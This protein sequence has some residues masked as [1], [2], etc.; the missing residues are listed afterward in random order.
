M[1]AA[2]IMLGSC[3]S[4]VQG[5]DQSII[6][7]TNPP[8]ATCTLEREGEEIGAVLSTPASVTVEK[9]KNDIRIACKKD[10]YQTAT[11][12]NN[13]GWESGSGAAGVALDVVLTLGISSAVDSATGADNRY[14]SPVNISMVPAEGSDSLSKD[15][16]GEPVVLSDGAWGGQGG[17]WQVSLTLDDGNVTGEAWKGKADPDPVIGQIKQDNLLDARIK[18]DKDP[19]WAVLSGFFPRVLLIQ[20][21]Q[22][23]AI[24]ELEKK[25]ETEVSLEMK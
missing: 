20:D 6:V 2:L 24:I 18:R 10:G 15:G 21:D 4:I 17:D 11:F 12:Y 19:A 3:S 23:Q 13:S 9:T 5:T 8:E 25:T 7:N 1:G 22:I 14:Q 16:A